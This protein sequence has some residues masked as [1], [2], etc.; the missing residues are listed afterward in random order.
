MVETK[1]ELPSWDHLHNLCKKIAKQI[2]DS[3]FKPDMVIALARGGF[4]PARTICDS[5]VIKD[6]L[7]VK[8]DHWGITAAKDGKAKLRY[9]IN[10]NLDDKN[11]LIVDDITDTGESLKLAVDHIKSL[12][13]KEVKT[14]TIYHIDH[15]KIEPDF[16][17][18]V[19]KKDKWTWVIWPWNFIEDMCN[20]M[21]KLFDSI[22]LG[23]NEIQKK[24]KKTYD[25]SLSEE[26]II[27]LLGELEFRDL[28]KEEGK[29]WVKNN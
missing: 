2:K 6:L 29:G 7:S 28:I 16:Y 1:C 23:I 13:A 18:G 25:I 3:N 11:V 14:A 12:K 22:P 26:T 27:E 19:I 21:P 5:L 24:A 15:S 4:V 8:I 20:L 10:V 17:G 9:P